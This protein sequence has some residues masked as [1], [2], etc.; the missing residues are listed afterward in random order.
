M[1]DED[2][3]EEETTA[4]TPPSAEQTQ[5]SE[6]DDGVSVGPIDRES[7]I[8]SEG[9][10]SQSEDETLEPPAAVDSPQEIVALAKLQLTD[11]VVPPTEPGIEVSAS[12]SLS[13][14]QRLEDS[15]SASGQTQPEPLPAVENDVKE[16]SSV[17]VTSPVQASE[18]LLDPVETETVVS[19]N[20]STS[21]T[22]PRVLSTT[23]EEPSILLLEAE[24]T[25]GNAIT[26]QTVEVESLQAKLKEVEQR[27]S[28]TCINHDFHCNERTQAILKMYQPLLNDCRL[29]SLPPMLF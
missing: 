9:L 21:L 8:P 3:E 15:K 22:T 20:V 29:R 18:P 23:S 24:Q 19:P 10:S 28:G 4:V 1:K 26:D 17:S 27:F 13:T 7:E 5:K 11:L 14:P 12:S 25:N 2:N 16:E 6:N